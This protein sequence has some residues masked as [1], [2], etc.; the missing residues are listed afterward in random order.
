MPI[1]VDRSADR[2]TDGAVQT[3]GPAGAIADDVGGLSEAEARA[4]LARDGPNRLPAPRRRT[5]ATATLAV[6]RQPMVQLLLACTALYTALGNAFDGAVLAVSVVGV[7]VISVTQELRTQR[8][9]EVLRDLSSP[10]STV[11]R[12]GAVRR[13]PSQELV[14]GDRLV[15]QEGDRMACDADLLRAHDLR[16]DESL[17]TGESLPVEKDTDSAAS[18]RLHA[19]TLVVQGDGIA[20]VC[21]TGARTALGRIGGSLAAIDPPTSRLQ[22]ELQLLV[23]QIATGALVICLFAATVFAWREG[24]W[25]AGLL[26]GLTLAM[27]IV[28]EEFAVVWTVMLALG[29][30][31]L[32]RAQVLTRQPQAIE[33]LG[34]ATVLC[35]DKTGTLTHNR[36]ALAAA[37]DGRTAWVPTL[38]DGPPPAGFEALLATAA[39]A[40]PPEGPDPMDRAILQRTG[41]RK[42]PG[43]LRRREGVQPGRPFVS[44]CWDDGE[45]LRFALKGA[46]EAVLARC[47]SGAVPHEAL[48]AQARA[49]GAEGWRVIAVARATRARDGADAATAAGQV[50]VQ[51]LEALGLLAF[52]DPL[53]EEVPAALQACREAG[54]RVVMITGDAPATAVAIARAAGLLAPGAPVEVLTGAELDALSEALFERQV[55]RTA[56]YARVTPAHKLRIVQALQRGGDVVAMT[57]DGVNDGPALRAADIGVAMGARG[58]D[59]A[60]E[61][62]TLVLMDDRFA[63]LVQAVA[64]GR[65]IFANLRHALGYL[66]AVHV[67]IVGASLWPLFGGPVLLLPVHVVLLE[68]IIDPAC[69]LVFESE[70]LADGA[71]RSPPRPVATRLFPPGQA[72]RAL[73]AGGVALLPLAALQIV[74]HAAGWPAETLRMA[75]MASIVLGNLVLLWWYRGGWRASTAGN[76]R[77]L[78]VLLAVAL[79]TLVVAMLSPLRA[80]LGFPAAAVPLPVLLALGAAVAALGALAWRRRRA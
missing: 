14:V 3:P 35:V 69:S 43:V 46:P 13:I 20:V 47:A 41:P 59:V 21:A 61:A 68:L 48:L 52:A 80:A 60:R 42:P 5:L 65:R 66:F 71:M 28:P 8:V 39:A 18:R 38:G 24:S 26:V 58:T 76:H 40:C 63:A 27:A 9:L 16:A 10:R 50:P 62:A 72:L 11:V 6:L 53:R 34:A 22:A 33:A 73:A 64:A 36:M 78:N 7:A 74:G 67:P 75:A 31:R 32:A 1:P 49:W 15:V 25:T 37:H 29:A 55:R 77:F 19:G 45:T 79:G 51:G 30:R 17:L 54:V 23:R 70:P 12:D 2:S 44:Q 57:G 56:I 4:R